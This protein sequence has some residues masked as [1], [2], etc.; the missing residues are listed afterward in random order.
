MKHDDT[1]FKD[2]SESLQT[3]MRESGIEPSTFCLVVITLSTRQRWTGAQIDRMINISLEII[4]TF[5]N[6]IKPEKTDPIYNKIL[7]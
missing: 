4:K 7:L 1:A 5:A 3:S 2:E 6:A